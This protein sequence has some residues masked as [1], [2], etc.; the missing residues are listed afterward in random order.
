[1]IFVHTLL[2]SPAKN[3]EK[4]LDTVSPA[5][6]VQSSPQADMAS[7]HLAEVGGATAG[8]MWS[9]S[10]G[11]QQ[12]Q[13]SR[14]SHGPA[15]QEEPSDWSYRHI[16]ANAWHSAS[17]WPPGLPIIPSAPLSS[18]SISPP[19]LCAQETS[20]KLGR[21]DRTDPPTLD[22]QFS[23]RDKPREILEMSHLHATF[24]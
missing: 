9:S 20:H 23:A 8:E 21:G 13:L 6:A 4:E 24:I 18:L 3:K 19:W 17:S 2:G 14:L 22:V 11:L 7:K 12:P 10:G 16:F 15:L 1:M 5:P